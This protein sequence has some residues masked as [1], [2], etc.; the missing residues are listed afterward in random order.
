[1]SVSVTC[2]STLRSS[3]GPG[4]CQM[5][6]DACLPSSAGFSSCASYGTTRSF[7]TIDSPASHAR[8][9]SLRYGDSKPTLMMNSTEL[10]PERCVPSAARK[11]SQKTLRMPLFGFA[12][13]RATAFGNPTELLTDQETD[14]LVFSGS[15]RPDAGA[16]SKSSDRL[17]VTAGRKTSEADRQ[18]RVSSAMSSC[19]DVRVL[20]R[21]RAEYLE[22][23]GMNLKLEEVQRLCGLERSLCQGVLDALVE[24]RFLRVRPDGCY[25]RFGDGSVPSPSSSPADLQQKP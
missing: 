9:K 5:A 10:K 16:W 17:D 12:V 21:I 18:R 24:A 8:W 4:R 23:P 2:P 20:E 15:T 11:R 25:V 3:C 14:A 22:M 13:P 19:P 6:R 7:V 1:M